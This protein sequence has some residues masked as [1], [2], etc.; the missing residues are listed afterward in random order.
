MNNVYYRFDTR[1]FNVI[2]QIFLI[3]VNRIN[4]FVCFLCCS[5]R[6]Q[7]FSDWRLRFVY[8]LVNQFY[9]L[10]IRLLFNCFN[11]IGIELFVGWFDNDVILFDGFGNEIICECSWWWNSWLRMLC[12]YDIGLNDLFG[13]RFF[14]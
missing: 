1:V 3:L 13:F 8:S 4:V 7:L 14:R 12:G 6:S 11:N 5:C 9:W 10:N 2:G